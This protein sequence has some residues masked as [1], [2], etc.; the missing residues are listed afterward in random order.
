MQLCSRKGRGQARVCSEGQEGKHLTQLACAFTQAQ[1]SSAEGVDEG[2]VADAE[3]YLSRIVTCMEGFQQTQIRFDP[4]G[5]ARAELQLC[6]D[7]Y[8]R[9][10]TACSSKTPRFANSS[11][12]S[13]CPSNGLPFSGL[14]AAKLTR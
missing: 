13:N 5:I 1:G 2:T 9:G 14:G 11:S 8:C 4:A 3:L 10:G 12:I 6:P 7:N